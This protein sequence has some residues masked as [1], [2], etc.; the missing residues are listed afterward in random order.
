MRKIIGYFLIILTCTFL[1]AVEENNKY[2][3]GFY[4]SDETLTNFQNMEKA[5]E[6]I[7]SIILNYYN[8]VWEYFEKNQEK[9][10]D[11]EIRAAIE[12]FRLKLLTHDKKI[13]I[14]FDFDEKYVEYHKARREPGFF[15]IQKLKNEAQDV[16]GECLNFIDSENQ[17]ERKFATI[18]ILNGLGD[19][20]MRHLK[21]VNPRTDCEY[22]HMLMHYECFHEGFEQY[23]PEPWEWDYNEKKYSILGTF[24]HEIVHL[25]LREEGIDRW[26]DDATVE[27]IT[28]QLI[29]L[30]RDGY[31]KRYYYGLVENDF[32]YRDEMNRLFNPPIQSNG[33][34]L[35]YKQSD[36]IGII[37]WEGRKK[38]E[39]SICDD[40]EH[41]PLQ[42][43][44][45]PYKKCCGG[46]CPYLPP[47]EDNKN[48]GGDHG[49]DLFSYCSGFIKE[50]HL[51][52][53]AVI[54]TNGYYQEALKLY[55]GLKFDGNN[56]A[57]ELIKTTPFL[58]IP[59]GGLFGKE[60]D[61]IFKEFLK[62]YVKLNGT[63]VAFAEQQGFHFDEI[64]PISEGE[65]MKSVGFRSDE[66]C[67]SGSSY[68][69]H[70]HPVTSSWVTWYN[71]GSMGTDG[72]FI[73]YPSN[74]TVILRRTKNRY[75]LMLYY[76]YIDEEG[77]ETG[78]VIV[79][80][81]FSDWAAAHGQSTLLERRLVRDLITFAKNPHKKIPLYSFADTNSIQVELQEVN[82]KNN[83]EIPAAKVKL[84][85]FNPDRNIV[86]HETERSI[87]LDPAQETIIS[88]DFPLS[89]VSFQYGY[90]ICHLD[91]I[92]YDNE[93][94][95]V[96][97]SAESDGG[98][99]A[100]YQKEQ[101]YT[102]AG[103]FDIWITSSEEQYYAHEKAQITLHVKS[104]KEEPLTIYWWHQWGHTG[105]ESI[106]P[107]LVGPGEEKEYYLEV[108]FPQ[109]MANYKE[110]QAFFNLRYKSDPDA[111]YKTNQ[112]GFLVKGIQT[113]S[114][115]TFNSQRQLIPGGPFNYSIQSKFV[116]TPLPG[117]ST[118]KLTLEKYSRASNQY[119]EIKILKEEAHDFN[120]NGDFQ[121]PGTYTPET[122]HPH[123]SYRLKLEVTA[124][125]GIKEQERVQE[126]MYGSSGFL[127]SL[128]KMPQSRLV[129]G[130]SYTIPIKITNFGS[131]NNYTV[132]NGTYVLVLRSENN[133]EV[134][135]KEITGIA[136]AAGEE[137]DLQETFV[138][139]P[140]ET[141]RYTLEYNY[142]DETRGDDVYHG[143]A[144]TFS[145]VT[146]VGVTADKEVYEYLDTAN[147]GV[148]IDGVGS[149]TVQLSCPE[150]GFSGTRT[151]NIPTGS[152]GAVEQFQFP[153]GV[154]SIY[155][156]NV[157]V[158]DVSNRSF[159]NIAR[160]PVNP[161]EL[162]CTGQFK[163]D[164]ARA[165]KTLE[166]EVNMKRISGFSQ[167]LTG[168]L[169]ITS[170]QLNYQD[171][172]TVTLQP[173]GDN[174]FLYT[175]PVA[176]EA[177]V[178]F[179][180][181]DTQFNL[182]GVNLVSKQYKI[183][184]PEAKLEFSLPGASTYNAS[185]T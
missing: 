132:K 171:I 107:L 170:S 117:N 147:I 182:N 100:V 115:L 155:T 123:G 13:D 60:N 130:E 55:G 97:M 185:D 95:I 11:E 99:F 46:T 153:I 133:H 127:V 176:A 134:F 124:P 77:A 61:F 71:T 33:E 105:G 69:D 48:P 94:N 64:L 4:I 75:P 56:T 129:P 104:Y 51:A 2:N 159:N 52:P 158:K 165:G 98:R 25:A 151:V 37:E 183:Y 1:V 156:V 39:N 138:F 136:I 50:Y 43:Y 79:C 78:G 10:C 54:Y 163:D 88:L 149:Y 91:Y 62:Q 22:K 167:P 131:T 32:M 173:L 21:Y 72:Y 38:Q 18:N 8:Q 157:E 57:E 16:N 178:G 70:I 63:I 181:V 7:K 36:T 152:P 113:V 74:S 96:Q 34:N 84:T 12:L 93:N 83:A 174:R 166:F 66:S 26:Q 35:L 89:N 29:P 177:P 109:Y 101:V 6:E 160:L 179:Y 106:A 31:E 3:A 87:G 116:S 80:S 139:N 145:Y 53:E 122:V 76:P 19:Y 125:N 65:K 169:A 154:H 119:E 126:F 27:D 86:L 15:T 92:L 150:A 23:P 41:F 148:A 47:A 120:A 114:K 137:L 82:I 140:V 58:V 168:E 17:N 162:D 102:P 121:F 135:R 30:A 85:A 143:E 128:A 180:G 161:I 59:S 67:Y 68:Y 164:I 172:K 5:K 110:F 146:G 103:D 142:T 20:T 90:G 141:G 28:R 42:P 9:I 144:Q 24:F 108:D 175:I 40:A 184:L 49:D 14:W 111:S 73:D 44:V 112:K 118:I 45:I 81:L